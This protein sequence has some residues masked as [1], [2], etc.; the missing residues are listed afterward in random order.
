MLSFLFM[1]LFIS[2]IRLKY[3]IKF[4]KY[5]DGEWWTIQADGHNEYLFNTYQQA[6]AYLK[7]LRTE[8]F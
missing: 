1:P 7:C 8:V 5:D 2:E 4:M 6:K 3:Y